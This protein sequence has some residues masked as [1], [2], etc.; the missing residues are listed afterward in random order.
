MKMM[1]LYRYNVPLEI[2]ELWRKQESEVLLPLQELAVTR[3]NLFGDKNL[4]IQAPTSSGKTFIAEMAAVQ[5][6]LRRKKVVYLV[7]LKALAEEKYADFREKYAAYGL[8]VIVSTRDRREFDRDFEEG[9]FSVAVVVYE[10]LA[11]LLVRRPERL[12]E[13]DLVLADELEL[14]SDPERWPMAELLL[15]RILHYGGAARRLIGL[16]AVIG[17]ADRLAEWMGARL[18]QYERRP[19]ELRHGVLYEG[20]FRYRTHNE[21]TEGEERLIDAG[22]GSAWEQLTQNVRAF[23][24]AGE[25]CLI[26]VKARHESR[27][28]AESLAGRLDLPPAKRTI[29]ALRKLEATRSRTALLETLSGG[30]AFHNTDLSPAER[31]AVE[32]GFRRG[33]ILALVSTSTLAMGLNLPARNVFIAADKWRYD[34]RLGMPW[35]SPILHTEYENM[36]GRAGRY[37]SGHVFGRSI[38]IA[39]TPFDQETLW[40]RYVEGERER[41][42]PRLAQTPLEDHVLRLIAS[43]SCRTL[44]EVLAFM[45]R[46]LSGRWV[47]AETLTLDEVEFRLRAAVNRCV[48]AG[49]AVSH[50]DGRIEATPFG[51]AVAAKGIAIETARALEHWIG[52]CETLPWPAIDLL[53]AAASTVDGRMLQVSLTARE[54][55]HANY[56]SVLKRLTRDEPFAADTP[57]NRVRNG[58]AQPFFE[59]VRAMKAALFLHEWT[60]HAAIHDLEEHYHTTAGQVLAAAEQISW[61]VDATAAIAAAAGADPAFIERVRT[62]SERVQ[63]GLREE[64][65]PLAR[66]GAGLARNDILALAAQRLDTPAAIVAVPEKALTRWLTAAQA[67]R[68]HAWARKR[69]AQ[70]ALAAAEMPQPTA[71][72]WPVLIVDDDQPGEIQL[73]GVRIPLQDKQYRLIRALAAHPGACVPY[74]AIYEAVWGDVIVESNQMHFQKRNLIKRVLEACPQY[75]DLIVTTPKRGFK[76]NLAPEQV[77]VKAGAVSSAA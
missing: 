40:R 38:L 22:D 13:I 65:L 76:L 8:K 50:P 72:A 58:N 60:E 5:T 16:S 45:E 77:L 59:E 17:G 53:F 3:H 19:V 11:Q 12:E 54:Y 33:E 75:Q 26:F 31:R 36:G 68:L 42:D 20:V 23:A 41:I 57:M 46:T 14:L 61:L 15:T 56:P 48:D 47:W 21:F 32:E 37:G 4:L 9:D 7:P 10:K 51:H 30:A 6:A 39:T 34:N 66:C 70:P 71:T 67:R 1:E 28:G 73:D 27:R 25:A 63:Y 29:E 62:L 24:S 55:D 18:V 52:Q 43:R 64:A 49:V 2:I 69:G 74:D 35:K 44:N